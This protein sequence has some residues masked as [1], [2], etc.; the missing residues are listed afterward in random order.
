MN[1]SFEKKDLDLLPLILAA[2]R[3]HYWG[4]TSRPPN[5][6]FD[7]Y[8]EGQ[9]ALLLLAMH[10]SDPR[11]WIAA[12]NPVLLSRSEGFIDSASKRILGKRFRAYVDHALPIQRLDVFQAV[13]S[14]SKKSGHD[15]L[16][17]SIVF[18]E[19]IKSPGKLLARELTAEATVKSAG[20]IYRY[21]S[22]NFSEISQCLHAE[23]TLVFALSQDLREIPESFELQSTLKPCRMCAAFLYAVR[24]KTLKFKVEYE[25]DDPGPLAQ[26]TLLDVHGYTKI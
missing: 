5:D 26:N 19:R 18:P 8:R 3:S 25:H 9:A 16:S 10:L 7:F 14:A 1:D 23:L 4:L 20:K 17:E 24:L 15:F 2:D 6:V 13:I 22:R 11:P 12:R 21:Y